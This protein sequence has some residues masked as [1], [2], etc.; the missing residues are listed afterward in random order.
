MTKL[1]KFERN[2]Y[3]DMASLWSPRKSKAIKKAVTTETET[4]TQ[5]DKDDAISALEKEAYNPY[6]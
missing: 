6:S 2:E 3:I 1:Y 5:A 4:L